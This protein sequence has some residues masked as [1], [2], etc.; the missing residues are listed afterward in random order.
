MAFETKS[1]PDC[2]TSSLGATLRA[3]SPSE[4]E[5][6][7]ATLPPHQIQATLYD[8]QGTWA[9]P[10]QLPPDSDWRASIPAG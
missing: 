5:R 8:W 7:L 2:S 6:L 3:L 9:R 1:S 4:R 10:D